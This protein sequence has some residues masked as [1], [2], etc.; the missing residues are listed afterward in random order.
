MRI[1]CVGNRGLN[2]WSNGRACLLGAFIACAGS[3]TAIGQV[4][5]TEYMYS[6]AGC[7]F[8]EITNLGAASVSLAGWSVDD[9]NRVAGAFAIGAASELAPGESA[10]VCDVTDAAFRSQWNLPANVRVVGGMGVLSGNSLGR[11]DEINLY[12]GSGVLV[13]RLTYGDQTFS[14]SPRTQNASAWCTQSGIGLNNPYAWALSSVGDLQS[15]W[16]SSV[17]DLGSPGVF[18]SG[19]S[20]VRTPSPVFSHGAGFYVNQFSLSISPVFG[21]AEIRYTL[22]GSDPTPSSPLLT[23]TLLMASREGQPNVISLIQTCA[24]EWW[25]PPTSPVFKCNVVRAIAIRPGALPSL[26]V[27]STYVVTPQG[28]SR[29]ALPVV[30]IATDPSNFWDY[31]RGIYVPGRLYDENYDQTITPFVRTANYTQSGSEWE[32]PVHVE[33]FKGDGT[34]AFRTDAGVRIHGDISRGLWQKSLRVYA[35][36]SYGASRINY[37]FFGSGRPSSFKRLVLRNG[38]NDHYKGYF[39]D[40]M[41]HSLMASQG[42]ET[43]GSQLVVVFVNGE[44]WGVQSIRERYD[45]HYLSDHTGVDPD[46]IDHIDGDGLV[47]ANVE[48]GDNLHYTAMIQF[49]RSNNM[50][51]AASSANLETLID[52][53]SIFTYNAAQIYSANYSWPHKNVECWRPRTA[54]GRWRWLFKDLDNSVAWDDPAFYTVDSLARILND[55]SW[56]TEVFRASIANI[57]ARNRFITRFADMLNTVFVPQ[58]VQQHIIAYRDALNPVMAEHIARWKYPLLFS[59]WISHTNQMLEFA[60]ERQA[61]MRGFIVTDF[62]LAGQVQLTIGCDVPEAVSIRLNTLT[63]APE[64]L[65]WSG[66]YFQGVPVS[67]SVQA[68]PEYCIV[69]FDSTV[70]TAGHELTLNLTADEQVNVLLTR[71]PDTNQDGGIDGEDVSY[72]FGLW[73]VGNTLADMNLDGGVDGEDIQTFFNQWENG[74]CP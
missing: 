60:N 53:D 67:I 34:T 19:S 13:D 58:N 6:G 2:R 70:F 47:A 73:E 37:P 61:A 40:D 56:S 39:R 31:D 7:E 22:D 48:E 35:D 15:T 24:N 41:M 27:T 30:S 33:F 26:P 49:I 28:A 32:R 23:G 9:S 50:S 5:I 51:T 38:G 16:T 71:S 64:S 42:I 20:Q 11:N 44:Y 3:S 18:T 74:G 4:R 10:V 14:G 57:D 25:R 12:D 68:T 65:P 43:L 1:S 54:D 52:F 45:K 46:E 59:Y 36:S 21:D 63:L 69:G 8:F 66:V 55:T 29:Y 17:G 62:G 72:F